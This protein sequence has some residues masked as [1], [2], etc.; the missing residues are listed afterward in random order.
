MGWS[1]R[2]GLR[3]QI[4]FAASSHF[5]SLTNISADPD[6]LNPAACLPPDWRT[7][8]VRALLNRA[9][10]DSAVYGRFRFHH[11]RVAEFLAAK[12]LTARIEDGCP[13]HELEHLLIENV[14]GRKVCRPSM[15]PLAAWLCSPNSRWNQSV[16]IGLSKLT[17]KYT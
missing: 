13:T 6:A 3:L 4:C 15:R 14:R 16:A 11:R 5:S 8:Q 12:W 17:L 7:D 10:F 9:L 1:G 2:C